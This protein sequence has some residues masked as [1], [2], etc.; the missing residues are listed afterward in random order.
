[1]VSSEN[2]RFCSRMRTESR[3]SPVDMKSEPE[4]PSAICCSSSERRSSSS[5]P[6]GR[7]TLAA[8]PV[9]VGI[10]REV[11]SGPEDLLSLDGSRELFVSHP[12]AGAHAGADDDL[13]VDHPVEHFTAQT[14]LL[15]GIE[16]PRTQNRL[17]LLTAAR[18]APL[19]VVVA[20]F[21]IVDGGD[22]DAAVRRHVLVDTPQREGNA[23]EN[24]DSPRD[25]AG[26]V[27]LESTGA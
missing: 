25:P 7:V 10:L 18:I 6:S 4:T 17:D 24:H 2:V 23:D 20:D 1:M 8:Q 27:C 14:T 26:R 5:N 22:R 21:G 15:V 13:R 19:E 16:E 3:S 11:V 12:H 9:L